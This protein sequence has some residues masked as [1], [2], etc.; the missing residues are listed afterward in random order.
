[1]A[2][3]VALE[4]FKENS[5]CSAVL[6]FFLLAFSFN[7]CPV[8]PLVCLDIHKPAFLIPDGV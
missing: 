3:S 8:S 4:G 6:L 1:M 5:K 7:V 2:V